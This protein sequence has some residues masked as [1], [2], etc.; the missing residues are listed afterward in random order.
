[1]MGGVEVGG[2]GGVDVLGGEEECDFDWEKVVCCWE[3]EWEM[4]GDMV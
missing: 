2:G 3:V 1:M 4:W